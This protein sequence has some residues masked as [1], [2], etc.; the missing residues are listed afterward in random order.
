MMNERTTRRLSELVTITS[1]FAFSSSKFNKD[2]KGL[3]LIRIRDVSSGSTSTYYDGEYSEK[4]LVNSGDYL[5]SMDGEFKLSEWKGGKALL[6]QRVCKIDVTASDLDKRYLYYLLPKELKRI[7]NRT[8][9]VTVKH[10]STSK[11]GAIEV[12]IPSMDEQ[13]RTVEVL[14]QTDALRQKR[15]DA[16]RLLDDYSKSTFV[17]MFGDSVTNPKSFSIKDLGEIADIRSGVTKGRK[18]DASKL[19]EVPYMRVANVQDGHIN[20]DNVKTIEV[21]PSD[22]SRY[23]LKNGDLLLT[24]GGDPD[25]LGRGGIWKGQISDC[26]H[27]NHIFRVRIDENVATPEFI[28]ALIS[29]S[30]GKRYF[31]RAA[32]QT[33]GIATINMTQLKRMPIFLPDIKSQ[34]KFSSVVTEVERLQEL[35][36]KQNVQI[37]SY[38]Q[39]LTQRIFNNQATALNENGTLSQDVPLSGLST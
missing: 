11:I 33:S 13:R 17:D 3:P 4:F 25:K 1:G 8:P 6:N 22:V 32:K 38:F 19:V 7:E 26:I 34:K 10:L 35:H 36:N 18:L 27:Q 9:F 15:M 14:S 37:N 20:L 23:K 2:D 30:Y 5:I 29:S 16:L 24:E 39:A 31:L 21:L 28:S 12:H